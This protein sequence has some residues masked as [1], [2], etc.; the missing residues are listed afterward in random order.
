MELPMS[1]T[2][3]PNSSTSL[4]TILLWALKIGLALLFLAAAGAKI[5]GAPMMVAEFGMV[6]LGQWFRYF[7][8]LMEIS[9]AIL[10]L[11]PGRTAIGAAILA[12]VCIGAFFAQLLAIHM[13]IV[14]TIV[15]AAI[16]LAIVW[17]NRRQLPG[18]S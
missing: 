13:D 12:G 8:A 6:G 4:K 7:T 17:F 15:L 1:S 16:F 18:L 3:I 5:A 11:L 14:H 9:G 2:T 10:L